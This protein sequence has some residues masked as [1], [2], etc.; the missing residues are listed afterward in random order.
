MLIEFIDRDQVY[1]AADA[2]YTTR[3][4]ARAEYLIELGF[5]EAPAAAPSPPAP[6]EQTGDTAIHESG[7]V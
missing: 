3:D 2:V 5:L 6:A 7:Q 1:Y 4:Q